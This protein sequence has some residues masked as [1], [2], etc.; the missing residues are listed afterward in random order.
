MGS[1][2]K[3]S[4]KDPATRRQ[5]DIRDLIKETVDETLIRLGVAS[6]DPLDM[7][8]DFQF[9]REFRTSTEKIKSKGI[10]AAIGLIVAALLGVAWVGFTHLL[11]K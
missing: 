3:D 5:D 7:Q 1:S 8:R 2:P 10:L 6:D 9:L 4:R 11:G